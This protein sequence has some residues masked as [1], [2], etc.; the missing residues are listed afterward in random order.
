MR[1]TD[2]MRAVYAV[3]VILVCWFSTS[4]AW[5]F[6]P[7]V[8]GKA[9][10]SAVAGVSLGAALESSTFDYAFVHEA[11]AA[12][13]VFVGQYN[14]PNHPKCL[15]KITASGKD[16][17]IVGSDEIDGSKQWLLKAT[18][19]YPGTI[20]VDFSPKGGPPDLL[21]VYDNNAIKWPDGNKWTKLKL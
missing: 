11:R 20:F 12:D 18:E 16:I 1:V 15:R 8:L 5:G 4:E 7:R 9:M 21:G 3:V 14:D 13:S 17:T 6:S 2:R 19:D 10:L